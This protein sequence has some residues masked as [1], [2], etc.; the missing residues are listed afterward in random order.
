[1]APCALDQVALDQL[2]LDQVALEQVALEQEVQS[3]Q[4]SPPLS[5]TGLLKSDQNTPPLSQMW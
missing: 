5:S 2:A 3:H 1:M 4:V